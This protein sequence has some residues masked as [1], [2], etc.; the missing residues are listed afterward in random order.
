MIPERLY[1]VC[2]RNK[3][4]KFYVEYIDDA[5]K[6]GCRNGFY[7]LIHLD[8]KTGDVLEEMSTDDV[9]LQKYCEIQY[10]LKKKYNY[11]YP[12]GL[13]C[14]TVQKTASYFEIDTTEVKYAI[15]NIKD[16]IYG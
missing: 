4:I 1:A 8:N 10:K 9:I 6:L 3:N 7:H 16:R 5:V 12:W 11:Y 14:E 15:L 13:E 2:D